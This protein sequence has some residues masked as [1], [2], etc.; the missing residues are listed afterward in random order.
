MHLKKLQLFGF[1]SFA[2]ET[3]LEFGPGIT[4]VVGPNG[5]GKSNIVDAMLWAL[6][7]RSAK[8]LR[9]NSATDVIFNG[10]GGRKPT[11]RCEVSLFFDNQS[12]TLPIHFEEVQVTRRLFRDGA[13]EYA[14][15]GSKCR[16]R[17]ISD[18]FLDTGVGPDAGC[19]ISQGEIDAI[20]SA[21]PEDRRGLI[22]GAAGIQKYH[23][24]RTETRR[25]LEKVVIDLV[26]ISDITS[27]LEAQL[28]PLAGQA[29]L[30][31]EY[32]SLVSRLKELQLA[33]LSRDYENRVSRLEA[34]QQGQINSTAKVREGRI[35]IERLDRLES[36]TS[37]R[38]RELEERVETLSRDLTEAVS[39]LKGAEGELAVAKERRRALTE[40]QE[41]Q[42]REIG[43]LRARIVATSEQIAATTAE[44]QRAQNENSGLNQA[45]AEAENKLGGANARLSEATREL[46]S[47]QS[48][49]IEAMR[50]GQTRRESL[51]GGK[52]EI[53]AL[54]NRLF[55]LKK[56]ASEGESERETLETLQLESQKILAELKSRFA[57]DS[58]LQSA[59]K[60]LENVRQSAQ[61][62]AQNQNVLRE[63][64]ARIQS[65]A[66]ALRELEDSLE[67]FQG[68]TRAILQ[69]VSRG[70]LSNDYTPIA[71]AIR[72]PADLE[73]AIEVALGGN[74]NNL[75][76]EDNERAK[77]GIEWL[78]N[79]RAGRATFLPLSALR[80][81]FLSDRTLD[82]LHDRAVVGLA[83]ELVECKKE[84]ERAVDHLLSRF[85]IVETLDDAIRL[86]KKCESGAR[87][88][89]LEGE[90]VLPAGAITGGQ[91]RQKSSG[92]LARKR[93]L[94]EIEAK[95]AAIE[96]EIEKSG[97]TIQSTTVEIAA[98][99]NE[100]RIVVEAH[101]EVR[102]QIARQE[103]EVETA[104]RDL[105]KNKSQREAVASQIRA[106][107]AALELKVE[108]QIGAGQLAGNDE[109]RARILEVAVE[110]ARAIAA[111]RQSEK[112]AIAGE[113]AEVR[114]QF[115]ATLERLNSMRRSLVELEKAARDG[116]EQIRV[117]QSQIDRAVGE[118]AQIVTREA[119]L[120]SGLEEFQM[121]RA[122]LDAELETARLERGLS[123]EKLSQ[124]AI[125]LKTTRDYLHQSEEEMHR[126]E[127][128][129]ASLQ[130]E[131]TDMERRFKEEFDLNPSAV[132]E[133]LRAVAPETV[134]PKNAS[135]AENEEAQADASFFVET[136]KSELSI[137]FNRRV[138]LQEIE[139]LSALIGGLGSVNLGA[140]AQ[141]EAVKERLDFL[142]EQK[143]DL[144]V[145]RAE[146]DAIIAEIDG[147]MREQFMRTF[148][149]LVIEFEATFTKVFDGGRTHLTLT[150]PDNLLETGIDLRVQMPGKAAQDIS[151]LS[152]GERALTAL[153]F[154]MAILRVRPAPFVILDEVDAPLDQSNVGRFTDLL[155]EF[156]D[157]TQFIVI[158]HNNGTMQA[159]DVLYGVTQQ[160]AGIST[161][162]S[163][164]LAAEEE[165]ESNRRVAVT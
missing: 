76:C 143:T 15:G 45:A 159:A 27:E 34:A 120:V 165:L 89:S 78:K 79:N 74:V 81:S 99:E 24:R 85:I 96:T 163:V 39:R 157:Q 153:S 140:V 8:A 43:H 126:L 48:Q 58:L 161:L 111:G 65:R 154:L 103:R 95:I 97:A 77:S 54:E 21:K 17:D 84:H 144:E 59:R 38:L 108:A 127:V 113:V 160:E 82:V 164:R 151:L 110:G 148:K 98:R 145:S 2:D 155:R 141:F 100:L 158:T 46:Q 72:A 149:A 90:V 32:D 44:L 91:G 109:E 101:N 94:D 115:G 88:V 87:L 3:T 11:G 156:T 117:K 69:A 18:L 132:L 125:E 20:L 57:D 119:A 14:L 86:S 112:D 118:D 52:A 131:M 31:R 133:N 147:R 70:Q 146:L 62:A 116:A 93:E 6:G 136:E 67:G 19:I 51:A 129:I 142:V 42:A 55:D 10:S 104:A 50:A 68:G 40:T 66:G 13:G 4:A 16:L 29:K 64:R 83:N 114:A 26:R 75:I 63:N 22:E 56:L 25:R 61:N 162:M 102:N 47:V 92:L 121:R 130:A 60:N 105:N 107:Q 5:S 139:E 71:D 73:L 36:L 1:K 35:E 41:F 37:R 123:L 28:E 80:P 152:G 30:A 135:L 53:V 134:A 150:D 122:A 9:G 23:A 138:A 128:R 49:I 106:S 7:E 124:T 12:G 137:P 33:V